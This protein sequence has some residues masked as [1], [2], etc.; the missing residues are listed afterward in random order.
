[1][2]RNG[3]HPQPRD[4]LV[5]PAG[6]GVLPADRLVERADARPHD[7][8]R[9]LPRRGRTRSRRRRPRG[10]RA[11]TPRVAGDGRASRRRTYRAPP[12]L[13]ERVIMS[14]ESPSISNRCRSAIERRA[15]PRRAG[16]PRRYCAGQSAG[17][18]SDSA[19][20]RGQYASVRIS[21]AP[22]TGPRPDVHQVPGVGKTLHA[23]VLAHGRDDDAV[24]KGQVTERKRVEQRSHGCLCGLAGRQSAR[25]QWYA[26]G[27][28][29]TRLAA[30]QA[31]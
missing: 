27:R 21:P 24:G 14:A 5:I 9:R 26:G 7:R 11:S 28:L 3:H 31:G 8:Q 10:R 20:C 29:A 17:W 25:N 2:R 23:R 18:P 4:A 15:A 30:H 16:A 6:R 1:M 19:A 22:P 12:G 13:Q